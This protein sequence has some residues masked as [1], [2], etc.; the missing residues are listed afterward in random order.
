MK[1][2]TRNLV[3]IALTV[4]LAWSTAW[5]Q[6][7]DDLLQRYDL[8]LERLSAS[9]AALPEAS[10]IA[11]EEL[12]SAVN[13][14]RTL[15]RTTDNTALIAA[16]ERIFERAREA[17]ANQS[18]V[19][20]AVQVEVLRGGFQRLVYDAALQSA[21][22]DDLPTARARLLEVA[23]DVGVPEATLAVIAD[24]QRRIGQLRYALEAGV[25]SVVRQRLATAAELA[26]ND[27]DA[28][29]RALADA[30]GDFLLVQDSPRMP[31]DVN[32]T[33]VD[34]ANALVDAQVEPLAAR[35]DTLGQR[36][37]SLQEAAAAAL[38]GAPTPEG[39][40][41][42]EPAELPAT[43]ADAP[44][45]APAAPEDVD[46]AT[47][48]DETR[49]DEPADTDANGAQAADGEQ[50]AVSAAELAA[51][52]AAEIAEQERAEQLELLT[53]ELAA[54]GVAPDR[55]EAL[56]VR[57]LDGGYTSLED[58]VRD[59]YA[60]ASEASG[61]LLRAD[62]EAARGFVRAYSERYRRFL[63]PIVA[64]AAPETDTRTVALTTTLATADGLRMQ[65]IATLSAHAGTLR[66]VLAGQTSVATQRAAVDTVAFWAGLV[67]LIVI[68][69]LGVLAFVPLYLLNLAFG[70]GNRNWRLVGVAL[71]LLLVPV[72]YEALALLGDLVAGL[73]GV[74]ALHAISQFSLFHHPVSQVIWA[75]L[76]LLAILF[77]ISGLYGICVQFGLLGRRRTASTTSSE[78]RDTVDWDEEF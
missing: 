9:V 69:V 7:P 29:Y 24:E 63:A 2:G 26:P 37:A 42:A 23:A 13:T 20:L 45:P 22:A 30:Y 64:V 39:V 48:P 36:F 67:R 16:M 41:P 10:S 60:D 35:L 73:T 33:F 25:A 6:E 3:M 71:F 58:V 15:A 59:L 19:D 76:T 28:A 62:P 72:I 4:A 49:P 52:I 65:D 40:A 51:Q 32:A 27:L 61:A 66:G 75:A 44:T 5:A 77:A 38:E 55:R 47:V 12:D 78:V 1:R 46:P 50:D 57:V 11:R 74:D 14:M 70:G 54:A 53:A 18:A 17:I 31:G 43:Q 21:I 34:A 68:V 56:A 8:A